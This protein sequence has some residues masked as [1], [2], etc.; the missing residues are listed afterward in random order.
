MK[1]LILAPSG[2]GKSTSIGKIEE[3]GIKGLNPKTTFVISTRA[4][5]L[6]FKN[7]HKDYKT[8]SSPNEEGNRIITNSPSKIAKIIKFL[9]SKNSPFTDIVI[10]D[11][12]FTMQDY[13][14][15]NSL[16]GGFDTFKTIGR[17]QYSIYEVMNTAFEGPSKNLWVLAHPEITPDGVREKWVMKTVGKITR[18]SITP[19]GNFDMIFLGLSFWDDIENKVKKVFITN[20]HELVSGAKSWIGMFD[21]LEIPNDLGYIKNK[22]NEYYKI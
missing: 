22:I 20:E 5:G 19:E 21:S 3:L 14:M 12:N 1:N 8:I 6:P 18:D 2:F 15:K 4:R 11:Y 10:D 13:Y 16:V 9:A 7:S 17:D